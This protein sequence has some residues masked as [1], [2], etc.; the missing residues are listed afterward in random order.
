MALHCSRF[1]V[2]YRLWDEERGAI[3]SSEIVETNS[4]YDAKRSVKR[5][6]PDA[7]ITSVVRLCDGKEEQA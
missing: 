3:S 7:E 1:R 2:D 5:H 4:R 6:I